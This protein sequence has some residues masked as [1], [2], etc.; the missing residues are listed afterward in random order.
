MI[1]N[2]LTFIII[3]IFTNIIMS[4]I[5]ISFVDSIQIRVQAAWLDVLCLVM[6]YNIITFIIIF[7]VIISF[8]D[9][10]SIIVYLWS[11]QV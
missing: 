6:F 3:I 9:S 2:F 8:S 5:D 11:M 10:S 7:F 4:I 1:I